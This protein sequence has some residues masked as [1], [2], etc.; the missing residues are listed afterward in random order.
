MMR[1]LQ[2]GALSREAVRSYRCGW[3][4]MTDEVA[5]FLGNRTLVTCQRRNLSMPDQMWIGENA[6]RAAPDFMR[7]CKLGPLFDEAVPVDA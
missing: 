2:I 1:S 3:D 5:A 4:T 7:S 6:I